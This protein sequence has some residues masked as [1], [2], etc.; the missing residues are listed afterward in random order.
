MHEVSIVES[1][2]K[3]SL[4]SAKGNNIKKINS[5]RI[6][7]GKL[8]GVMEDSLRFAFSSMSKGTILE[9]A[10]FIVDEV[11]A[12]AECSECKI[13]FNI[14]HFNKICPNCRKFCDNI[15]SGYELL[16]DTIEGD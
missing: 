2:I 16:I 11:Q 15:I 4:S 13:V 1:I 10:N 14:D 5:I 3:I 6:K 7:I 8:S 9:G 12:T